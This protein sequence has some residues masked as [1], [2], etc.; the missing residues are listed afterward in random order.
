MIELLRRTGGNAARVE[1]RLGRPR[2]IDPPSLAAEVLGRLL[3]GSGVPAVAVAPRPDVVTVCAD[4]LSDGLTR[5]WPMVEA[6]AGRPVD[7]IFAPQPDGADYLVDAA[8]GPDS[9]WAQAARAD[10]DVT[11]DHEARVGLC[12]PNGAAP[13]EVGGLDMPTWWL[14][15]ERDLLAL[16]GRRCPSCGR[17]EFPAPPSR[18]PGCGA[19]VQPHVLATAG[20][21]LTWTVDRLYES[22]VA[23]GMA[24]VDLAGGGRFYGQLADG[25]PVGTLAGGAPVR[26]VP[27]V[28]HADHR[29]SAYFWK[30]TDDEEATGA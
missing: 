14:R 20:R 6:L 1:Y 24:V 3:A 7:V 2:D 15:E 4:D 30:V 10:G 29:R 26:L 23:T 22:R 8:V 25:V 18:C 16:R 21:I 11:F 13:P 19:I 12:D 9:A 28:L 27:R 5:L 17:V